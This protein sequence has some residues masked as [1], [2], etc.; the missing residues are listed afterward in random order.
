MTSSDL[1]AAPRRRQGA[2]PPPGWA[3]PSTG[4][5]RRRD[6]PRGRPGGPGLRRVQRRDHR[7]AADRRPRRAGRAPAATW[8]GRSW[9]GCPV[10][11][12]CRWWPSGWPRSGSVD[13]VICLGAVIRGD[14]GHYD[15]VAGECAVGPAAGPARH[16]HARGLRRPHHRHGGPG[17]GPLEPRRDQQGPRGGRDRRSRRWPCWP[18]CSR[19]CRRRPGSDSPSGGADAAAGPPQ[20]LARE[21]HPR[22]VRRG[23][24]EP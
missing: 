24:P 10:P 16:R 11:S 5:R 22:P 18:R 20:G 1:T 7:P 13:A 2:G 6:R 9:P 8:P 17:A 21:G 12:S 4:R 15:F 19:R 23:R 3:R 14:T